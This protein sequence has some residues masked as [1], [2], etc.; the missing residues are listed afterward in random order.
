MERSSVCKEADLVLVYFLNLR[1][2]CH[3]R[4]FHTSF[5]ILP[6]G[7]KYRQSD[8]DYQG[9][10]LLSL[11]V[12]KWSYSFYRGPDLFSILFTYTST[13]WNFSCKLIGPSPSEGYNTDR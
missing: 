4:V 13:T 10:L 8:R 5:T 9:S 12:M 2:L 6:L 3:L 11:L 7:L 1:P